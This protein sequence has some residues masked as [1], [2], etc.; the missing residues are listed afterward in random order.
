MKPSR[1]GF[2]G[3][4]GITALSAMAPAAPAGSS[5][6]DPLGVRK[7]FPAT[8]DYTFLNTAYIGLISQPVV[9]AAHDWIEARARHT[10]SVGHMEAKKAEARKLFT[11]MVGAGEDEIG[12][13]SSTTEGENIVVNSLDFKPGDNIVFDDIVYPSTPVIYRRLQE[14]RG[15]EMRVVKNRGGAGTVED[16][17]KMVDN[18]TRI[19]SVA[20]VSNTSGHRHD[21]KGLADL[22]HAHGAYLYADAV[23]FMGTAPVDVRALGVDFFTTGTYKWIMAGFGVALFYVRRELLDKIQAPNV[24]WMVEKRLPNNEYQAYRTARKFEYS[25]PAY[26]QMYELAAALAYMK[27]IGLGKIEAQSMGLAKQLQKGLADRGFR[28]FTP[29]G[30]H[31]SIVSFYAK[32]T[33]QDAQNVLD[34]EHIKVSLQTEGAEG[35]DSPMVRVR[36]APAFFNNAAEV[37]RFLE[38]S[39]KLMA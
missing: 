2:L 31:S 5:D 24:G 11:G 19:V 8:G 39:G 10:Y 26:G 21:M 18:R 37:K 16:F 4:S 34:A 9:D 20:W 27:R 22:A 15:V 12:F 23:Q 29:E 1:R 13:L 32:K 36:V 7:D 14:T 28:M 38:V 3:A 33:M 25:S 6:D 35:S 30:N 17:A